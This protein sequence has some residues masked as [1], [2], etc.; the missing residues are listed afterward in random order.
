[1]CQSSRRGLLDLTLAAL[2]G[3][4]AGLVVFY[5][6]VTLAEGFPVEAAKSSTDACGCEGTRPWRVGRSQGLRRSSAR[7]RLTRYERRPRRSTWPDATLQASSCSRP[8]DPNET[9]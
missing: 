9:A 3:A 2:G 6:Y 4:V 1:M 7:R 5:T 8:G